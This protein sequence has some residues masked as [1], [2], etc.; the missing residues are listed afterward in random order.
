MSLVSD[1]AQNASLKMSYGAE[2]HSSLSLATFE[3]PLFAGDPRLDGVEMDAV[4]GYVAPVVDNDGT[5]WPDDPDGGELA[6]AP[7]GFP[8]STAAWTADG[9]LAPATHWGIRDPDTGDLWDVMP[10]PGDGLLV[11]EAGFTDISIQLIVNY[12]DLE[13]T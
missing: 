5:T 10:L 13:N 12:T 8:D 6:S 7:I 11:D 4:G 9:V 1:A 2:R 3:V